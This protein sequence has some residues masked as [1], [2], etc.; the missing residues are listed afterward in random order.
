MFKTGTKRQVHFRILRSAHLHGIHPA[1]VTGDS[2]GTF[3]FLDHQAIIGGKPQSRFQDSLTSYQNRF[4]FTW[5]IFFESEIK[6]VALRLG[7]HEIAFLN[8]NWQGFL[9]TFI[10][11]AIWQPL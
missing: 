9:E 3:Y 7:E 4:I 8:A 2:L 11:Y 10:N 5:S 1:G 6:K